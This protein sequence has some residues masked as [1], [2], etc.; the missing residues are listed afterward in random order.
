MADS[1]LHLAV[2]LL[3]LR[4]A[5]LSHEI[6][7]RTI[8]N[9]A[10]YAAFLTARDLVGL[11][12]QSIGVHRK[13]IDRLAQYPGLGQAIKMDLK[14]LFDLRVVADYKIDVAVTLGNAERSIELCQAII[15]SIGQAR[16]RVASAPH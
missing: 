3:Q 1:P 7:H 15:S 14:Q 11:T 8:I 9:R 6:L 16:R 13:V 5:P 10:Y 2:I 4:K 12:G